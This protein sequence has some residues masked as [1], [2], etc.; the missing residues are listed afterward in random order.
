[1]LVAI[2]ARRLIGPFAQGLRSSAYLLL[3]FLQRLVLQDNGYAPSFFEVLHFYKTSIFLNIMCPQF[4][5]QRHLRSL[6]A[7]LPDLH[8]FLHDPGHFQ[9]P[10]VYVR[11]SAWYSPLYVGSAV[12]QEHSRCRKYLQLISGQHVFFNLALRYWNRCTI[13]IEIRR[14][15][16][17]THSSAPQC[18]LGA[19]DTSHGSFSGSF[20]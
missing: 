17:S 6:R 7:R 10:C 2:E 9:Q 1:M 4:A 11:L 12:H 14:P 20:G 5:E 13:P 16:G 18:P 8:D 3:C 19:Q 15:S